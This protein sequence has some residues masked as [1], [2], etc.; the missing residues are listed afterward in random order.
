MPFATLSEPTVNSVNPVGAKVLVTGANGFIGRHLVN[1]LAAEG[2]Q[3][4]AWARNKYPLGDLAGVTW[5]RG[6]IND[7]T[8]LEQALDGVSIIYHL[9]G[10]VPGKSGYRQQW[11]VNHEGTCRLLKACV[12]TTIKRLIFLS[13]V[14]VYKPPLQAVIDESAAIGGND[15]YGQSK[16]AAEQAIVNIAQ[17]RFPYVILRPCQVYG[18]GDSIG[19][20]GLVQSILKK[21]YLMTAGKRT[22]S[23]LYI[24]DLV[25]AIVKAGTLPLASACIFNISGPSLTSLYDIVSAAAEI[26]VHVP[27]LMALPE[28]FIRFLLEARWFLRHC[29]PDGMRPIFK[30]YAQNQ[31]YGSLLLGGPDYSHR[32][33]CECLSFQP[34]YSLREGLEKSLA[35]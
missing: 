31:I 5:H 25:D 34:R 2:Y 13:S 15:S 29:K 17:D 24:A 14:C 26:K 28:A 27:K 9:A 23:L 32:K 21:D 8:I 4:S 20:T 16:A 3:V 35:L 11:Q 7:Q 1:R 33:A 22:F 19:F 6:D 10:A 30:S 18:P 12:Q